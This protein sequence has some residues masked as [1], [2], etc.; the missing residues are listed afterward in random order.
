MKKENKVFTLFEKI[1]VAIFKIFPIKNNRIYFIANYGERYSCN[2]RAYFEY[3]Y[4]YHRDEFDFYFCLNH[5]KEVELPKGVKHH[6]FFSIMDF[7][8]LYTSKYIVNNCRFHTF[9]QKR[10]KQIYIQTWH[11]GVTLKKIE[12]DAPNLPWIYTRFAKND[13]NYIDLIT[14]GNIQSQ[15]LMDSCFYCKNKCVLTGTPRNDVLLNKNEHLKEKI[16]KKL[17]LNENQ[18]IVLCAPTFRNKQ[19]LED[20]MINNQ[21]LKSSFAKITDKEIVILYRFHPNV[22]KKSKKLVFESGVLN[23]SFYPDIQDLILI[24]DIMISDFSSCMFDMM[25]TYKPCIVYTNNLKKYLNNERGL[26][27]GIDKTPFKVASTENE[28]KNIIETLKEDQ[29]NYVGRV[30]KFLNYIGN[31]ENGDACK[32]LYIEMKKIKR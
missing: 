30:N 18:Y 10:K 5:P 19:P 29:Q 15:K 9:F 25:L 27:F 4:K 1:L 14:V 32:K 7:Y 28:L 23:V 16:R 11:G 24:S 8:Y 3:L 17:G 20:S 26:Y 2:P 13:A 21:V 22:A 12:K 31:V 6:K